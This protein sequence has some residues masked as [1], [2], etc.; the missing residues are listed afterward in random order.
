MTD[1]GD[2]AKKKPKFNPKTAAAEAAKRREEQGPLGVVAGT[3][4]LALRWFQRQ[5][6]KSG[7]DYIRGRFE[8]IYGPGKGRS[9]FTNVSL[10]QDKPGAVTRLAVWCEC[11][12]QN[13]EFDLD[14]DRE[15]KRVFL[16]Q[17]FK[18]RVSAKKGRN[19]GEVFNDI[20]RYETDLTQ[21]ERAAVDAILDE[22]EAKGLIGGS[23]GD[24][25]NEDFGGESGGG[26]GTGTPPPDDDW[27]PPSDE[28]IPF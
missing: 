11:V 13:E 20:E 25:S 4:L 22:L 19:P 23:D 26:G 27:Q 3:Y 24:Y 12:G 28:D 18:A 7:A 10:D 15:I 5:A 1:M 14:S 16:H 2:E 17:P 6:A 21:D 8:V 9:F